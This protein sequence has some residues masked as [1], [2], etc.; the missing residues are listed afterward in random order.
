MQR[1]KALPPGARALSEA[2]LRKNKARTCCDLCQ[3]RDLGL[4]QLGES[5]RRAG[6]AVG[7]SGRG[8]RGCGG[9]RREIGG[10]E[11]TCRK[12]P[13]QSVSAAVAR[14]ERRRERYDQPSASAVGKRHRRALTAQARR[15][16]AAVS[17]LKIG[18][19]WPTVTVGAAGASAAAD[20]HTPIELCVASGDEQTQTFLLSTQFKFVFRESSTF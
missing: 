17:A 15:T 16:H 7:S 20:A 11:S 2:A 5:P 4:V 12:P 14:R 10:C 1:T 19:T 13:A 8:A 9:L 18:V 6:T 3:R